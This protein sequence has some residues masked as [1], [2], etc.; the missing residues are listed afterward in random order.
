M[1]TVGVTG[2][3]IGPGPAA[4]AASGSVAL[5]FIVLFRASIRIDPA[6]ARTPVK[7]FEPPRAKTLPLPAMFVASRRIAPPLPGPP[8]DPQFAFDVFPLLPPSANIWPL[9]VIVPLAAIKIGR[10]HV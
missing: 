9:I 7:M 2:L 4:R 6:W 8:P 5:T 10:A 3:T 1:V